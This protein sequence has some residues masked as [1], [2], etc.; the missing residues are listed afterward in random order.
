LPKSTGRQILAALTSLCS[1]RLVPAQQVAVLRRCLIVM[2]LATLV[3]AMAM[4]RDERDLF[5]PRWPWIF[6]LAVLLWVSTRARDLETMILAFQSYQ[7]SEI[8][9]DTLDLLKDSGSGMLDDEDRLAS[10]IGEG[11]RRRGL[12]SR[13]RLAI[14]A[15]RERKRIR[16]AM[17]MER[18]EA[19]DA[20]RV[21][22]I[23]ARLHEHGAESLCDEDRQVLLRVSRA[24]RKHRESGEDD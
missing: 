10:V 2:S 1:R 21:D 8:D 22:E 5:I 4:I 3:I 13:I 11:G 17:E 23:L 19:I 9:D 16:Q 14:Q 6:L 20:T 18:R 12:W 15:R 7:P 24:L